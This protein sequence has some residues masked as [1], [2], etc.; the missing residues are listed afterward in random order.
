MEE[1]GAVAEK[2]KESSE[3]DGGPEDSSDQGPGTD[4][5]RYP[6]Q[7][8]G[9]GELSEFLVLLMTTT[10]TTIRPARRRLHVA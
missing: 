1:G 7:R 10:V 3:T 9:L 8:R 2:H 4:D 6:V 5:A